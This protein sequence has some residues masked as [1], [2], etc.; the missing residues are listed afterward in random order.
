[1]KAWFELRVCAMDLGRKYMNRI[2]VY[3]ST[4]LGIYLFYAVVELLSFFG[5]ISFQFIPIINGLAVFDV[6]V[7]LT[8]M[9]AMLNLGAEVNH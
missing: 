6:T 5:I 2:F 4:F 1:M 7:V 9:L 3:S 8:V